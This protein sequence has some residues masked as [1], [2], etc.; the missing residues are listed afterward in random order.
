[1]N[2]VKKLILFLCF[3]TFAMAKEPLNVAII[4]PWPV[5]ALMSFFTNANII[6]MPKASM[7][8]YK[9]SLAAFF[10]PENLKA[11]NDNEPNLEELLLLKADLYICPVSNP[12]LCNALKQAGVK[13]LELS[14]NKDNYSSKAV[15][16]AWLTELSAYFDIKEKSQK[17][18]AK[19]SEVENLIASRLEKNNIKEDQK[20]RAIIIMTYENKRI[21]LSGLF[22][23]YLLQ[24]SGAINLYTDTNIS[25]VNLEELYTLNPDV[26]YLTNFSPAMPQDLI[27]AKEWQGLKAVQNKRVYKLPLATYRS[28]A[29]NLDLPMVLEFMALKNYPQIFKDIDIKAEYKK[30]FKEFYNLNLDENQLNG[31][32][33]PSRAAGE[34]K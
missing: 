2:K 24:K 26:I 34:T 30:H 10:H 1:M 5:P 29:P 16:E 33:N 13:V 18:I 20:I 32:L 25:L 9:N 7:N 12:K 23:N 15:L 27:N 14:V 19:T 11:K 4:A 17:L 21:V 6:Y 3:M 28:F 8:A 31:I 22:A